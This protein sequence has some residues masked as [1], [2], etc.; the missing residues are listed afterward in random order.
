M[1]AAARENPCMQEVLNQKDIEGL[2]SELSLMRDVLQTIGAKLDT[3]ASIQIM[4]AQLQ[5]RSEANRVSMDRA[6]TLI[7][8]ARERS[9]KTEMDVSRAMAFVKGGALIGTVLFSFAQWYTLQQIAAIQKSSEAIM[10]IDR[11][12]VFVETKVW[13]ERIGEPER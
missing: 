5:E 3:M 4:V 9:N 11:R 1:V 12:L 7:K 8:E 10:A 13:P 2:R 6:F